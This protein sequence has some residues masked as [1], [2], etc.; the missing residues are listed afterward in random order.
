MSLLI[1]L[2][3]ATAAVRGGA[4]LLV[5]RG[6]RSARAWDSWSAAAAAGMAA[7]FLSTGVTHFIEPQ[8]SGLEAIVPAAIPAP[9]LVITATGLLEFVLAAALLMPRTRRWA[10]LVSAL[11]LVALFPANVIAAGGVDHPDAPTTPLAARALL[12]IVFIAFALAPTVAGR[13]VSRRRRPARA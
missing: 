10:G 9:G 2:L 8:R 3:L 11:L 1:P 7:V 13:G 5:R 6:H 4:S 12:Q